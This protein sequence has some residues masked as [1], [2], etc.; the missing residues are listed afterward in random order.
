MGQFAGGIVTFVIIVAA[1]VQ[2]LTPVFQAIAKANN[3]SKLAP[4]NNVGGLE[5]MTSNVPADSSFLPELN[6]E[7]M[8]RP[9]AMSSRPQGNQRRNQQPQRPQNTGNTQRGQQPRQKQRQ[10]AG[11]KNTPQKGPTN[12]SPGGGRS[13]GTG[14]G[15]HVDSF[16]GQHV[17]S[18]I[19]KQIS[20]AVKSDIND[21]VR[22]HL[23]DDKNKQTAPT[24]ATTHGSAAAGDL[25][26]ALRS[27]EGVRQAILISEVLGKPKALRRS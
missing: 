25:L 4:G 13:P 7:G 9:A 19:G 8:P 21:Q 16:I 17:K 11:N 18:H 15:A 26:T 23:G 2:A 6:Q 27:P 14:V 12:P 24:A 3:K 5:N 1:I 20:D 22:S 10:P